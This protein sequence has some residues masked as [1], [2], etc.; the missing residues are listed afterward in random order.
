MAARLMA[1][2]NDD[3]GS[4]HASATRQAPIVHVNNASNDNLEF[5]FPVV[6]PH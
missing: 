4:S 1:G 2:T 6:K 3:D 5:N